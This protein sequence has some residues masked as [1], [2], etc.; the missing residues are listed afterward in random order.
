M[1]EHSW[2]WSLERH[3]PSEPIACRQVIGLILDQLKE[4]TWEESECFGIHLA[5]DEALTNAS[6]HGNKADTSK[7]IEIRCSLSHTRFFIEITDQG[8][9][10]DP[11]AVPD[12]T[13]EEHLTI[14]SGRGVM[15]MKSYMANVYYNDR[16][17]TVTMEHQRKNQ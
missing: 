5:L 6:I 13:D 3:I 1:P 10:F 16:G 9:G 4:H 7:H 8:N 2:T 12:P 15:L 14:P 17:N 11:E